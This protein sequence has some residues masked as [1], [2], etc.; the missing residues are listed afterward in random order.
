LAHLLVNSTDAAL[1][2]LYC[3]ASERN[4]ELYERHGFQAEEAFGTGA[5]PASRSVWLPGGHP[6]I[7]MGHGLA[8][9]P[10]GVLKVGGAED[11]ADRRPDQL[12]EVLAA[13]PEGVTEEVHGAALPGATQHLGDRGLEASWAS[14]TTSCTPCRP[15]RTRLLRNSR[16]NASVSA[17]PT[18]RPMTS[19]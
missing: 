1:G 3:A 7:Q 8:Q 15:R 19:R 18:S 2:P 14:E 4:K 12:L 16:Q 9:Q 5:A 6:A 11:G 13:V 17:A 10:P